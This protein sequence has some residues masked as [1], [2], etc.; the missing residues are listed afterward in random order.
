MD[1][2]DIINCDTFSVMN[3]VMNYNLKML[4]YS[5]KSLKVPNFYQFSSRLNFAFSDRSIWMKR[6]DEYLTENQNKFF[7]GSYFQ[8]FFEKIVSSDNQLLNNSS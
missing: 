7:F 6:S 4:H 8:N 3:S 5:K 2:N 1:F